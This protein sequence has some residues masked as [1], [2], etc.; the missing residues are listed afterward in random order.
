MFTSVF[1]RKHFFGFT[2]LRGEFAGLL[3]PGRHWIYTGPFARVDA[4]HQADT[5]A[6]RLT[7]TQ[8]ETFI[9]DPALAGLIE[10]VR[11]AD[12]QRALVWMRGRLISVLGP[13]LAAFWK[14]P[15]LSVE[16]FA[17]DAF[18][19]QHA[20]LPVVVAHPDAAAHLEAVRVDDGEIARIYR[21]G[22]PAADVGA[23]LHAAWK[24]GGR[25]TWVSVP[26]REQQLDVAGQELLTGDRVPLR[27]NLLVG[28]K[29]VDAALA[30]ATPDIQQVVYRAAQMVLREVVTRHTLD[31]LLADRD[32]PGDAMAAR[33]QAVLERHGIRVLEAGLRDVILP[34]EVRQAMH[35]VTVARQEAEAQVIRRREETAAVRSQAQTAKVL[36]ESPHLM[37]LRELEAM[38]TIM[39]S[40]H[41]RVELRPGQ[42]PLEVLR[43]AM[44]VG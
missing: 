11:V 42:E 37:R 8:L 13:G 16:M 43:Q 3:A 1:V 27:V 22:V 19:F 6:V 39:A 12:T 7:F 24:A 15:E 5:T 36:A 31:R 30:L 26:T 14:H 23:G 25:M 38:Q 33:L 35:Q 18:R 34:G 9:E 28:W 21:D 10:V 32:N 17:V 40:A 20:R 4:V 29:V 44:G 41:L 2:F